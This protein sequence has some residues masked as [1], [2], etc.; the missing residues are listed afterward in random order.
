MP[1]FFQPICYEDL[2][3]RQQESYNFQKASAVL[4]DYGFMTIRL[5]DDWRGADFIAQHIDGTTFI[6]VQLKGR[7][8]FDQKYRGR[9][10][11]VC[12]QS[13]GHWYLYPHDELLERVLTTTNVPNTKAW[14]VEGNYSYPAL[15]K[16]LK[17][18][19]EPFRLKA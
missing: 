2:S 12:F 10:I 14:A 6:K 9:D 8:T 5:T 4:A 19:L 15:T 17:V 11:H 7:A 13:S 18:L 3:P 16:P 1:T